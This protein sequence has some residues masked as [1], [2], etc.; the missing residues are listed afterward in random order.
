[1]YLSTI[2]F[3]FPCFSAIFFSSLACPEG[4]IQG[5]ESNI[6][7]YLINNNLTWLSAESDCIQKGGHLASIDG[8]F[9]NSYLRGIAEA[10]GLTTYWIGGTNL[11]I[12]NSWSWI[13]GNRWKYT[14]WAPGS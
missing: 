3:L 12:P 4:S 1:M 14:A 9:V 7:Y 13:D 11:V 10:D 5:M 2:A 8:V 6:C